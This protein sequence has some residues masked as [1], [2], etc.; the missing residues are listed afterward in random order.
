MCPEEE[1][2][3]VLT[4]VIKRKA[5]IFYISIVRIFVLYLVAGFKF[6]FTY[7]LQNI[8]RGFILMQLGKLS[9]FS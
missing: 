4:I 5:Q 7:S 3:M 1:Y 8:Q 6:S 9:L 2:H